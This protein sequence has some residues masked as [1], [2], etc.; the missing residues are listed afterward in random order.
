MDVR[1]QRWRQRLIAT[2]FLLSLCLAIICAQAQPRLEGMGLIVAG[3]GPTWVVAAGEPAGDRPFS[4]Q[5]LFQAPDFALPTLRGAA[6][7]LAD[8]QGKVVL[9]N[10]WATWC[11]PCRTEMPAIEALYQRYKNRG[12][13]VLA[14]NMDK[15]APEAVG[16]FVKEV[17]VT[18]PIVLDPSWTT[19]RAYRVRGLPTTLLID[20]AGNVVTQELGER[21]WMGEAS[22][23]AVEELLSTPSG[24][25]H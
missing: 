1:E 16:A 12:L 23:T 15:L 14:V 4:R 25:E 3:H 22:R 9:L 21:D 7:H 10:F 24:S 6:I 20:R 8:L 13:E 19:A 5:V 17:G 18:F 2:P 11:V